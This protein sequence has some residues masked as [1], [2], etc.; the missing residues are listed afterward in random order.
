MEEYEIRQLYGR[1][2]K[3]KLGLDGWSIARTSKDDDESDKMT[4]KIETTIFNDGDIMEKDYKVNLYFINFNKHLNVH[5]QP[6]I[7]NYDY[8]WLDNGRVKV[9]SSASPIPIYPNETV[10][11]LRI[12]LDVEKAFISEALN[13][14]KYEVTLFYSNGEDKMEGDFKKI[15]EKV[16]STNQTY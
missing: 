10:N 5:W 7:S 1:K 4:F 12:N 9:S 11:V 3:S 15:L 6:Q 2:I 14:L 13:D 8:T 16:I